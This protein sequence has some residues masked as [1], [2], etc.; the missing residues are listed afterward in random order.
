MYDEQI[1]ELK[2]MVAKEKAHCQGYATRVEEL[3]KKLAKQ[4]MKTNIQK[5]KYEG[6][7]VHCGLPFG[8][9]V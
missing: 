5:K 6:L 7:K 9:A 4:Q 2:K 1:Q 8:F 3:Q